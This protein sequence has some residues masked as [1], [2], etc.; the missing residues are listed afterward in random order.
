MLTGASSLHAAQ[1]LSIGIGVGVA[2]VIGT[3]KFLYNWSL[4]LLIYATLLPTVG[5]AC[6]M[7]WVRPRRASHST[8]GRHRGA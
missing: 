2:A 7:Q 6:Y 1:V 3:L 4:K 8:D 5:A